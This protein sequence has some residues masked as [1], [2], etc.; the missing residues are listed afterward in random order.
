MGLIIS[1]LL[2]LSFQSEQTIR[3][4]VSRVVYPGTRVYL[5]GTE[6]KSDF[7]SSSPL[8][9]GIYTPF[10]FLHGPC[11]AARRS[12]PRKRLNEER[13]KEGLN[14]SYS[15]SFA[16]V[17][18]PPR[19]WATSSATLDIIRRYSLPLK[20]A[21]CVHPGELTCFISEHSIKSALQSFVKVISAVNAAEQLLMS[22]GASCSYTRWPNLEK[23]LGESKEKIGSR[24]FR[25]V[26]K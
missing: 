20:Y 19:V 25:G 17:N 12:R 26:K 5:D 3:T 24:G 13:D 11:S 9:P 10:L 21:N 23:A 1:R 2:N 4:A 14:E 18:T 22:V 7:T 8:L 16:R 15:L 6:E